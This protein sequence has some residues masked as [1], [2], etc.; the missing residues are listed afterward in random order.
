M[1]FPLFDRREI[2]FKPLSERKSRVLVPR[3]LV[4]ADSRPRE[5]SAEAREAI[6]EAAQKI[7]SA[8]LAGRPVVCVFGAHAIKNGLGPVLSA[9]TS[10]GWLT[11]LATNGAGIIHDWEI[12]FQGRTS[13]DVRANVAH[14]EFGTWEET[15]RYINLALLVGAWEGLGYGQSIGAL[16]ADQGLQIPHAEDLRQRAEEM[17]EDNP[18][19]GAAGAD[20]LAALKAADIP[21]GRLSVPHPFR[22]YSLQAAARTLGIPFTGHPSIGHD[23]IYTHA[24]SSG[25][26]IG[27]TA[28]RDF[29]MFA[30]SISRLEGG[31]YLSVGSAVMSPMIFEK[32]FSMAQN[33]ALQRG[34]PIRSHYLMV[35]DIAEAAWDWQRDGEPPVD[36]PAYY[37][38]F[39]KTFARMGGTMRYLKADNRDFFLALLH[40]LG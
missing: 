17:L 2:R 6:R 18:E 5:L 3:D 12:A 26:A 10:Q 11:H 40:E 29:L 1:S 9:L 39:C 20:L 38:R 21:P 24:L 23:I 8:R 30:A 27:R 28:A 7:R 13:E 14:G 36:N 22:Q 34:S 16:I 15:G 4:F 32:A 19:R 31:V 25:G 37:L 35:V 33:V